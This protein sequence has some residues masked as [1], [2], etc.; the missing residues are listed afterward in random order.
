MTARETDPA[1]DPPRVDVPPAADAAIAGGDARDIVDEVGEGSF[2]S[3]DP[4]SWSRA[5]AS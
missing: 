4:P 1:S 3:S 2:P 5:V